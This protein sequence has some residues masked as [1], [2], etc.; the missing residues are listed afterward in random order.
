M[1]FRYEEA[2]LWC[3]SF[4][5][6]L[7]FYLLLLLWSAGPRAQTW[8]KTSYH[9]IGQ[10]RRWPAAIACPSLLSYYVHAHHLWI[11]SIPFFRIFVWAAGLYKLLCVVRWLLLRHLIVFLWPIR[12]LLRVRES[13][14]GF[15]FF[16]SVFC[17]FCPTSPY[18]DYFTLPAH[19]AFV[20]R[21]V[22]LLFSLLNSLSSTNRVGCM[23][24]NSIRVVTTDWGTCTTPENLLHATIVSFSLRVFY[25]V[26]TTIV[27]VKWKNSLLAMR[28]L[29]F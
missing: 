7:V 24:D 16:G 17:A 18:C 4:C 5:W 29:C 28:L 23:S 14:V 1:L 8:K 15:L 22:P 3:L 26:C 21:F 25:C 9:L 10:R 6:W 12:H 19:Q 20:I 11:I 27:A 2:F 13:L